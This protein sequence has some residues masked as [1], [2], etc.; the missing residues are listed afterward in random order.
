MESISI[1]MDLYGNLKTNKMSKFIKNYKNTWSIKNP[2]FNLSK[3]D[4][5]DTVASIG[6][7]IGYSGIFGTPNDWEFEGSKIDVKIENLSAEEIATDKFKKLCNLVVSKYEELAGKEISYTIGLTSQSYED[8]QVARF[9][10]MTPTIKLK[11]K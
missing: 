6:R 7:T 10:Y 2:R 11:F 1:L 5:R 8:Y 9:S 4:I 3:D